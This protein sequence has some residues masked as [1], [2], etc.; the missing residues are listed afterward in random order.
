MRPI[1]KTVQAHPQIGWSWLEGAPMTGQ[2]A[3]RPVLAGQ[4]WELAGQLWEL[5][6][7]QTAGQPA[8]R[9][10]IQVKKKKKQGKSKILEMFETV[11]ISSQK[12][13][14]SLCFGWSWLEG[15]P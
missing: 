12:L 4:L 5:A 8:P 3:T 9:G 7:Q 13:K 1:E 15:A 2:L 10:V 6:S 14:D 11:A